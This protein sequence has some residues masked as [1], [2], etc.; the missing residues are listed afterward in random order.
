MARQVCMNDLSAAKT[1]TPKA[2]RLA[3]QMLKAHTENLSF[4]KEKINIP[5]SSSLSVNSPLGPGD[6][7]H[8]CCFLC[9]GRDRRKCLLGL[10]DRRGEGHGP[11]VRTGA[12]GQTECRRGWRPRAA[13]ASEA[14][15]ENGRGRE[16]FCC[17]ET[18]DRGAQARDR[19]IT[20]APGTGQTMEGGCRPC[21]Q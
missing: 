12:P 20:M 2:L 16:D 3:E 18:Q 11:P 7:E 5:Q 21:G 14:L 6:G 8:N 9:K 13:R 19:D 4:E 1:R 17:V 10:G 15:K